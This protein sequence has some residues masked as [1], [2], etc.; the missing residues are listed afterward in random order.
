VSNTTPL[1]MLESHALAFCG[2]MYSNSSASRLTSVKLH[3]N[4]NCGKTQD[5][6][7]WSSQHFSRSRPAS[8]RRQTR[9]AMKGNSAEAQ[10]S[11]AHPARMALVLSLFGWTLLEA[12]LIWAHVGLALHVI[13]ALP[14]LV[15]TSLSLRRF[16]QAP[17]PSSC[18]EQ[19]L[20]PKG[21]DAADVG[22]VLLLLL[23][24]GCF[25]SLVSAGPIFPLTV[26]TLGM[27][28]IPLWKLQFSRRHR[29]LSCSI[30]WLAASFMVAVRFDTLSFMTLPLASWAVWGGACFSLLL[31]MHRSRGIERAIK[32]ETCRAPHSRHAD[33][34]DMFAT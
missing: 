28:Y 33:D 16:R 21:F 13:T 17:I 23:A 12:W 19:E 34:E 6:A 22:A 30:L 9:H 5:R 2:D 32:A 8:W 24:G 25:G 11:V 10:Q 15:L 20:Q 3:K 26:A 18:S 14:G 29:L 1:A 4:F 27:N 7:D 31:A